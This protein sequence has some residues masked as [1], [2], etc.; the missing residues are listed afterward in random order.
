LVSAVYNAATDTVKLTPKRPF[1]LPRPVQ[2]TIKG[3]PPGGLQDSFGRLID[4]A[5]NGQPGSN[6]VAVLG[7]E[8]VVIS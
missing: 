5:D 2:L 1:S 6:A 7:R 3:T 8:G 4:G